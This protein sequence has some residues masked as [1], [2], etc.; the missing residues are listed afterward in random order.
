MKRAATAYLLCLL[1]LAFIVMPEL[2]LWQYISFLSHQQLTNETVFKRDSSSPLT[3]DIAYLSALV[4][5][6]IETQDDNK[7]ENTVP[8]TTVSHTGMI[9]LASD[10]FNNDFLHCKELNLTAVYNRIPLIGIIRILAPP[11]R[12]GFID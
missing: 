2:Q 3:G 5:R 9:Y 1:H 7:Q 12:L 10:A 6:T 8:E 11:P 4:K